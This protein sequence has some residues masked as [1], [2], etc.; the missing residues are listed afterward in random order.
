M[1]LYKFGDKTLSFISTLVLARLLVPED[2][3]LIAMAMSQIALL[4]AATMFS[5]DL[6][7]IQRAHVPRSL[8]DTAFTLNI[9]FGI[10][11]VVVNALLAYPTAYLYGD[12]RLVP[13]ILAL[14]AAWLLK[15]FQNIGL[16]NFRRR[17]EFGK[18]LRFMLS[19]RLI[20]FVVAL[21]LVF[22]WQSYWALIVGVIV[23]RLAGL[24]L[25][26]VV[27]P[28]RPR[29][30]LEARGEL[31]VFSKWLLLENILILLANRLPSVVIGRSFGATSVGHFM[32]ASEI[33]QAP[34]TELVMP[35]NRAVFPGFS[36][37]SGDT[38]ALRNGLIAVV[39]AVTLAILPACVGIF[40]VAE[41]I[42]R[43]FLGAQWL[44]AL[45]LMQGLAFVGFVSAMEAY[46]GSAC[47]ALG[48]P[49][50]LCAIRATEVAGF[51]LALAALLGTFGI[52]AVVYAQF[53]GGVAAVLLAYNRVSVLLE[54]RPWDFLQ[55]MIR[56]A[57]GAMLMFFAVRYALS[58]IPE[59]MRTG[60]PLITLLL[61]VPV[62]ALAYTLA[63]GL[64]W[65]GA[66][67][68]SGPE[69]TLVDYLRSRWARNRPASR[70]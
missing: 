47:L 38:Q 43:A 21:S 45:P 6:M 22:A 2:F 68:P 7:L 56:P 42:I 9:L 10:G 4:E 60:Q 19:V 62:G 55:A 53:I 17:M 12:E 52:M 34:L 13:I 48:R 23:S 35:I 24:V 27:E 11:A 69:R 26:Y 8:Y 39:A 36:R 3:G 58:Q 65:F 33:A 20:G 66:G 63:I 25:S 67:R 32:I 5:F 28:F 50:L 15:S 14:S 46:L 31:L 16:V 54:I 51:L 70:A 57:L 18:E 44:P 61:T 1:L 40:L 41:P 59:A 30:S 37:M 49:R 64:L 29:V